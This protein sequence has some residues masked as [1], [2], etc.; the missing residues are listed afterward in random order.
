MTDKKQVKKTSKSFKKGDVVKIKLKNRGEPV[1][2]RGVI[3]EVNENLIAIEIDLKS[4]WCEVSCT[5]GGNGDIIGIYID[6]TTKSTNLRKGAKVDEP[7]VIDLPD[8]TGWDVFTCH[9][10]RYTLRICL[11]K[12]ENNEK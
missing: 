8:F 11:I 7:T 4:K 9:V 1:I 3:R 10:S 2:N 6:A 12:S 5:T